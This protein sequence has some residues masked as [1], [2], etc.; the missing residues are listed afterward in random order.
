MKRVIKANYMNVPGGYRYIL[1]HGLGPGTIPNDIHV[2][3]WKDLPHYYTEVYLSR[4]LSADE[5]EYYD[6]PSE[7]TLDK[8]DYLYEEDSNDVE[9]STKICANVNDDIEDF[10]AH[11]ED[12]LYD[13]WEE[14]DNNDE[15]LTL[16]DVHYQLEDTVQALIDAGEYEDQDMI[17]PTNWKYLVESCVNKHYN[18]Y[19]WIDK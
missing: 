1:K 3:R 4:P 11:L 7:T 2:L 13:I 16:Y 6:I 17:V 19:D 12:L 10:K 15:P 9:E 14:K 18:D 5:L 8:Y